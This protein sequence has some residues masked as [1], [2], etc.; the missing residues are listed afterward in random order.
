LAAEGGV[1]THDVYAGDVSEFARRKCVDSNSRVLG[2][3]GASAY[4]R[5]TSARIAS[6]TLAD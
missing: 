6:M 5:Q 2:D 3:D 4:A 1:N